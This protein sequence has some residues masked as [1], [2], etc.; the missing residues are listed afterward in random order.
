MS[1]RSSLPL[2]GV[3]FQDL[4]FFEKILGKGKFGECKLVG[5]NNERYALKCIDRVRASS[6]QNAI[7]H[8]FAEKA[9][10]QQTVDCPFIVNLH[11]TFK[12]TKYLYFLLE[13]VEPGVPLY[14]FARHTNIG[15]NIRCI[16]IIAAEILEALEHMHAKNIVYRD[17]K[18]S[19][20][21]V[22]SEG[23]VKI[24]DLGLAK[25]LDG[26]EAKCKTFCGTLHAMAPEILDP[27]ALV[28]GREVDF[29]AFGVLFYELCVGD[30]PIVSSNRDKM[31]DFAQ[32]SYGFGWSEEL[33]PV[34]KLRNT[35]IGRSGSFVPMCNF[36]CALWMPE[37]NTR[38]GFGQDGTADIRNHPIWEECSGGWSWG[39][40]HTRTLDNPFLKVQLELLR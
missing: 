10:L 23:H 39:D 13:L 12:D 24:V 35:E 31:F 7:R 11:K 19:N 8:I 29:W 3:E 16:L 25:L 2:E 38:L 20:V 17:L 9:A 6:N 27:E 33:A 1:S 30:P 40:I 32:K 14:K 5:Y 36:L 34:G 28:Y 37:P 4:E 21:L 26:K 18:G 15:Q 22:D